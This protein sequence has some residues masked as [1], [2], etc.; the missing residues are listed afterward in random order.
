[1]AFG[2]IRFRGLPGQ[3]LRK[4]KTTGTYARSCFPETGLGSTWEA[5]VRTALVS[6]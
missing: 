6:R 1:M 5:I 2:E 4:S 3:F